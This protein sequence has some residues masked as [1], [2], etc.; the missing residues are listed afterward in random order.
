MRQY[1]LAAAA[2][3]CLATGAQAANVASSTFATDAEGWQVGEFTGLSSTGSVTYDAAGQVITTT[4]VFGYNAFV[5][6]TAY[7]G[8]QSAV[9]GG[10]LRFDLSDTSND[11]FLASP[12]TLTGAG[13]T[14][15]AKGTVLPSTDPDSLTTYSIALI[16]ASFGTSDGGAGS[17][18]DATLQAD[19]DRI[20]I[21]ADWRTGGDFVTLDN[22]YLCSAGSCGP[23]TNP[24]PEPATWA[25]LIAGF[26][27]AGAGA[28]RR[29]WAA[30][31]A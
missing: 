9:F 12:F 25:M 5:A 4:D 22:V 2:S 30:E 13:Q 23:V 16:G 27:L 11:G 10:T 29:R 31:A 1:L 17:V 15:Y 3:L 14:I 18:S 24:V 20:A 26:G 19:L 28:R 8:D 7:L 6:P 21:N